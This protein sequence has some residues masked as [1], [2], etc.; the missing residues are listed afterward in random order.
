MRTIYHI[1]YAKNWEIAASGWEICMLEN[2]KFLVSQWEKN[3]ILTTEKGKKAFLNW[4]LKESDLLSFITIDTEDPPLRIGLLFNY[5]KRLFLSKRSINTIKFQN[6]DVIFC[7]SDFFPNSIPM[8][9]ISKKNK[10]LNF[11][12]YFHMLYPSIFKWYEGEF[13]GKYRFPSLGMIYLKLNQILYL[14]I[15]SCIGKWQI[16]AV[17]SYYKNYLDKKIKNSNIKK[18]FLKIFGWVKIL[19]IKE[20]E[21]IY[22]GAWMWRFHAQK[23]IQELFDIV[24]K[25]KEKKSDVKIVV[26]GGWG[27]EVEQE[28]MQ[29]IQKLWLE[30]NIDYKGF[31]NGKGRFEILSQAKVFLMTSYFEWRPIVILEL[32]KLGIPVVAY[33][34]PVYGV[35]DKWVQKVKILDNEGFS[36][37]VLQLLDDENCCNK[38]SQEAK[39]FS[40]NYSWDNTG[41]EIYQLIK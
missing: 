21:K 2:I 16:I 27:Q 9:W 32:L 1:E 13:I 37:K 33:D 30:N 40:E 3:C 22:D 39:E 8:Y 26:I 41:K 19:E 5:F 10:N 4:G 7:H 14:F 36:I 11:I 25:L 18:H 12:F 17:N 20:Q 15:I 38:I 31:L 6:G 28:F 23:G 34:L 35:Y 29:N 24:L